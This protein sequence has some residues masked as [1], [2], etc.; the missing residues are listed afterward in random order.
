VAKGPASSDKPVSALLGVLGPV[1]VDSIKRRRKNKLRREVIRVELDQLRTRLATAVYNVESH[2]GTL[3][4][5]KTKWTLDNLPADRDD[6]IRPALEASLTWTEEMFK[7][8]KAQL[9]PTGNKTL[10]L[11]RYGTPLL[12]ARVSAL[13]SFDTE[14]QRNLLEIKSVLV[15]L[16]AAVDQAQY[17]NEMTFKE[18]SSVNHQIAVDSARSYIT[19][20]AGRGT[21]AV[22]LIKQFL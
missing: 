14:A 2:I 8:V 15:F 12:D 20:S 16:D 13:G 17:F 21:R 7:T 19:L 3:T 6:K 10:R 22:E 9:A 18:M 5:G 4:K 11:Q 1:I